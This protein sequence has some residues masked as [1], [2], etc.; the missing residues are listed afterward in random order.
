MRLKVTFETYKLPILYRH[1]IIALIKE[2]LSRSDPLYKNP[3][4]PM[5]QDIPKESN[6][7]HSAC[8]F[9]L[10][11]QLKKKDSP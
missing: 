5:N 4:I 6:P 1:R 7:L 8:P 11:G 10:R 9:L 2:A 3:C